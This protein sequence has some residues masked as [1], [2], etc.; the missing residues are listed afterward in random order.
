MVHRYK[1]NFNKPHVLNTIE[2]KPSYHETLFINKEISYQ[3]I[4]KDKNLKQI[5]LELQ[6]KNIPFEPC[7]K[8][9][10]YL[11]S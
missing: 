9:L 7:K 1:S 3:L 11:Q 10:I 4:G 5:R 2:L 8:W 6:T